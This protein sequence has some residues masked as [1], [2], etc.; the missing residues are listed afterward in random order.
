LLEAKDRVRIRADTT[1][2]GLSRRRT[3]AGLAIRLVLA[4]LVTW[5]AAIG[6]AGAGMQ[7]ALGGGSAGGHSALRRRR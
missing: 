5:L 6:L 7:W 4:L 2:N 1:V 3:T